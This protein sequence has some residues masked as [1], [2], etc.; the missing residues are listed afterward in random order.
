MGNYLTK[1]RSRY[2]II[3]MNLPATTKLGS[4]PPLIDL[5]YRKSTA[6][7]TRKFED[8]NTKKVHELSTR[9]ETCKLYDEVGHSTNDCPTIPTLN[10]VLNGGRKC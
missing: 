7:L 8:L 4:W 3:L 10:E 1:V 9:V 2:E 5:V 6:Q